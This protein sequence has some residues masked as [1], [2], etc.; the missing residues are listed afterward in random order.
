MIWLIYHLS[1]AT[2]YFPT[3]NYLFKVN[4]RNTRTWSEI[5]L[6]LSTKTPCSSVSVVEQVIIGGVICFKQIVL[7]L[8]WTSEDRSYLISYKIETKQHFSGV[9]WVL[10]HLVDSWWFCPELGGSAL[11]RTILWFILFIWF[12]F[13][14]CVR[15]V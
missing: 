5:Y 4:S 10:V 15:T 12:I 1:M 13:A 11:F 7:Y 6:K 2:L 8:W 9:W 3:D 14:N